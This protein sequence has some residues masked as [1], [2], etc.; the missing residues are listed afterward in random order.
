MGK[1]SSDSKSHVAHMTEGDFFSNEKSLTLDKATDVKIQFTSKNGKT[2]VFD[3][4]G[5]M[6]LWLKDKRLDHAKLWVWAKD[7]K[8]WIDATK[9]WYSIDESTP[10]KHG[11]GAYEMK[12]DG[13]ID[14]NQMRNRVLRG[15]DLTNPIIRKKV[16]GI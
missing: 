16:L 5:C 14:F 6:I 7:K 3:D 4:V 1:W 2:W 9:A 10:M 15:E 11:F 13:D 12:K 8:S